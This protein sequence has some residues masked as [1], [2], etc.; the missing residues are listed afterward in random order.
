MMMIVMMTLSRCCFD[1]LVVWLSGGIKFD[2]LVILYLRQF[3][4]KKLS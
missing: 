4:Y 3:K 2:I 1:D